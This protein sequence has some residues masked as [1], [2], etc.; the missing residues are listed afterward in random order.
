MMCIVLFW[1]QAEAVFL[2]KVYLNILA[3]SGQPTPCQVLKTKTK[4]T[5]YIGAND[6]IHFHFLKTRSKL[7]TKGHHQGDVT[8]LGE[9]TPPRTGSNHWNVGSGDILS[10]DI[11]SQD[12]YCPGTICR[13]WVG[14]PDGMVGFC[15]AWHIVPVWRGHFVPVFFKGYFG[16]V[17]KLWVN[18]WQLLASFGNFWRLLATFGYFW[19]L[20]ATFGN[21]W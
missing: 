2:N 14:W 15:Q 6:E 17:C 20:L 8:T 16:N 7:L 1:L 4:T 18:F 5:E 3:L 9:C 13:W 21:F 11:M 19:Q 12:I 10:R